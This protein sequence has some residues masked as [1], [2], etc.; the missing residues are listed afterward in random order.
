MLT[1]LDRAIVAVGDLEA[2]T[3]DYRRLLGRGPT[4]RGESGDPA[5]RT[6]C[7]RLAS[8]T[9]ELREGL[10]DVP[11]GACRDPRG[12]GVCALLF[13]TE[14]MQACTAWLRGRGIDLVGQHSGQS[15][16]ERT[17]AS[18]RWQRAWISPVLTRGVAIGVCC[19]DP[20]GE[21]PPSSSFEE[22]SR[23]AVHDLDHVVISTGDGEAARRFYA[24]GLGLRLALDRGFEHRGL[25]ML[26]FRVGGVTVEVVAA[27]GAGRPD[28][29]GGSREIPMDR[30][31][32][33]AWQV[34]DLEAIHARLGQQEFDVSGHR[35]GHK[36]GTRVCTV[37]APTCEVPTLLIG[38]DRG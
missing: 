9:L 26:F 23:Q 38:A 16:D 15:T 5:T 10:L 14:D 20:D 34:E 17:G 8:M 3:R 11:E 33:L 35:A 29:A 21:P 24:E 27:L 30:F 7:F 37:R 25:R 31:A 18:R 1:A 2:A 36:P 13:E 12:E 19:E 6:A 28:R 4:I 22:D 32:G